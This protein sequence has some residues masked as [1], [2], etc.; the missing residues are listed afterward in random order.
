MGCERF[1]KGV[2]LTVLPWVVQA[3]KPKNIL[4]ITVD[5]LRP[6]MGCYGDSLGITPNMDQLARKGF[7]FEKAYCQ[8]AVSGPS[9]ASLLTGLRPDQLGV[10]DLSTHFRKK[11]P[12]VVTLPQFFK[13]AGYQ[14]VCIG[15]IFHGSAQTQDAVSWSEPERHN[16]SVK[17]NEYLLPENR[18]GGKANAIEVVDTTIIQ[19]E[20]GKITAE[21]IGKLSD[22]SQSGKPF[23][24]AVGFKKPHL[25]FGTP[26][27]YWDMHQKEFEKRSLQPMKKVYENIPS[28]ALHHSE[29]LRG[30]A[31]IPDIGDF[32]ESK[33]K[34]LLTAYYACATFVD[35]QIGMLLNELKKKELDKNTIVIIISDHGF[36]LG[37]Q[38]LWCKSTNFEIACKVPMLIYDPEYECSAT[39]VT[40]VV[41]LVDIYPTL[42]ELCG[43]E[44]KEELSGQSLLSVMKKESNGK[45]MAFSQFPRPYN[46]IHNADRQTHMGYTVRTK[47]WRCTLWYDLKSRQI[48]DK[49]LYYL[50]GEKTEEQNLSGKSEYAG[51]EKE[52]SLCIEEYRMF[53]N[54]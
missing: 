40:S 13:N 19:F 8:Q 29:E 35:D 34:E 2:F 33:V 43:F 27:K 20:D 48:T 36:H 37:E 23:F 53:D 26:R 24:L 22:F 17:K 42:L 45:N 18:H 52:L 49:E 30:Y 32:S 28:I 25:P 47:D 54:D 44:K 41:E 4:F 1:I 39:S 3:E 46:A 5:D 11:D 16:L 38:G 50:P 7:L 15:K 14:S 10:T 9:R 12:D 21:A 51:I 6:V 31:D